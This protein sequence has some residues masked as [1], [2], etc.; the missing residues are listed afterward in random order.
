M[1]IENID[2]PTITDMATAHHPL[3]LCTQIRRGHFQSIRN[4]S[5]KNIN[6]YFLIYLKVRTS[7]NFDSTKIQIA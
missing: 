5:V 7:T 2:V 6:N 1:W 4:I 3:N